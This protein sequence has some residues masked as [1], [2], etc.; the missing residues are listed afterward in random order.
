[1]EY[2]TISEFRYIRSAKQKFH[3]TLIYVCVHINMPVR[4]AVV[5]LSEKCVFKM[6]MLVYPLFLDSWYDG[7][8]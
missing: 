4:Q 5:L 2:L 3:L 6:L 1:M 8:R 7:S